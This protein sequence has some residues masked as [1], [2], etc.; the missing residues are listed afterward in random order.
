[1]PRPL[2]DPVKLAFPLVEAGTLEIEG[3]VVG[4]PRARDGIVYYAT[5]DGF[6]TAAVAPARSVLWRSKADHALSAGPELGEGRVLLRD[7]AHAIYVLDNKGS[8]LLKRSLAGPVTTAVR[9]ADG[10]LFLGTEDGVIMALDLSSGGA[11]LWEHR[12]G[13]AVTAG[14]VF[15]GA[16]VIFGCADGRLHALDLSGR[17]VWT[18]AARGRI[19]ADP[20]ADGRRVFFGTDERQFFALDAAT[21]RKRWSRRLQ[22]APLH[23]PI[24]HGRRV[25]VPASRIIHE[26]C[27]SGPLVLVSSA[28]PDLLAFDLATGK[29]AGRYAASGPLVAGALWLSPEVVLVEEDGDSGRQRLVFL[30]AESSPRRMGGSVDRIPSNGLS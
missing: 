6:L 5:R 4:Q 29:N 22:G 15:D 3:T 7:D 23:A 21:G 28:A 13:A 16:K 2:V 26:P 24:I 1:M 11:G 8:L 30:G 19:S 18:F 25:A 27:R 12:T 17:P 10:R 20:S 14:P 9:E